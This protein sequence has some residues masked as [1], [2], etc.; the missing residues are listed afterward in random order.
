VLRPTRRHVGLAYL[1]FRIADVRNA[2]RW[3]REARM[4]NQQLQPCS[5]SPGNELETSKRWTPMLGWAYRLPRAARR[6]T[7]GPGGL[8]VDAP[9]ALRAAATC[10]EPAG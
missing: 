3:P 4:Q 8:L 5:K 6:N 1:L 9:P 2:V 10:R 7:G